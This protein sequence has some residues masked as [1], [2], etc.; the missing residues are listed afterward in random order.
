MSAVRYRLIRA[1]RS[2]DHG[3]KNGSQ[4]LI[5][6]VLKKY[7]TTGYPEPYFVGNE[8]CLFLNIMRPDKVSSVLRPVF[9]HI[10][11][12]GLKHG[13]SSGDIWPGDSTFYDGRYLSLGWFSYSVIKPRTRTLVNFRD[14]L[15]RVGPSSS[16]NLSQPK[17]SFMFR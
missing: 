7:R 13:N 9:I 17:I 3:F 2:V 8:D 15:L 1:P 6:K 5:E 4:R 11:G 14:L 12:G 16:E 10:H